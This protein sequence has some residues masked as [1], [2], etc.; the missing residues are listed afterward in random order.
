MVDFLT[1]IAGPIRAAYR[2]SARMCLS[3]DGPALLLILPRNPLLMQLV[4]RLPGR[5]WNSG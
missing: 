5:R 3:L 2:D 4:L 1:G